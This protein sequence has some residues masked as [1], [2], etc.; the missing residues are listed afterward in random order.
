MVSDR[1]PQFVS[2][3]WNF[4]LRLFGVK[5]SLTAGAHPEGNGQSER[6]NQNLLQY[7][8]C[9][10]NYLQ[11]DWSNLLSCAEFAINNAVNSSTGKSPFEINYGFNPRMD[12]LNTTDGVKL[13]SVDSWVDNLRLI[14]FGVEA[15]L[16]RSTDEMIKYA[17]RKRIDHNFKVGDLV[18]LSCEN[19]R[20]T[21]PCKKLS[22]KRMG[23]FKI[24]KFV[25]KVCAKLKLPDNVRVHPVFHVSLLVAYKA[26]MKGQLIKRP[27]PVTIDSDGV[28]VLE[29]EAIVDVRPVEVV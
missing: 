8:T 21:R 16:R 15:A 18:W 10:V 28:P 14:Q 7:L 3:F 4:I 12:Y 19:L 1:G 2:E 13:H 6:M 5:R 26:P 29:V 17:N 20:V 27:M 23:P 25:N 9:Y 22:F 11:D 24:I